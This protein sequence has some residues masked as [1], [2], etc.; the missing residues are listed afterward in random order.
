MNLKND[1]YSEM[2]QHRSTVGEITDNRIVNM[3]KRVSGEDDDKLGLLMSKL[4]VLMV[5]RVYRQMIY[6]YIHDYISLK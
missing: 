4:Y 1:R 5:F 3:K 6:F 2:I